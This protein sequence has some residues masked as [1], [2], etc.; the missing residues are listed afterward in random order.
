MCKKKNWM[1]IR[2][3]EKMFENNFDL[4]IYFIIYELIAYYGGGRS[5]KYTNILTIAK[6]ILLTF[7]SILAIINIKIRWNNLLL[8]WINLLACVE[9]L[10]YLRTFK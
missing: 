4:L 6:I 1:Q 3:R 5:L 10:Y 2:A 7:Y 9:S 8:P